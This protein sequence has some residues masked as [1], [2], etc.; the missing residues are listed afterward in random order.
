[1]QKIHRYAV[2]ASALFAVAGTT[3]AQD[4]VSATP[5][6]V[7]SLSAYNAGAAE[8]RF[9]VD[10]APIISSWSNGF[11]VAP[12]LKTS[13]DPD[14]L[15]DTQLVGAVALSPDLRDDIVFGS[16]RDFLV[17]T[18]AGAGINP[19][20]NTAGTIESLGGFDHQFA[21]SFVDLSASA[22]NAAGATIGLT[23]EPNR[24]YVTRTIGLMSRFLPA[25]NDFATLSIGA[26][27]ADGNLTVRAD[28]FNTTDANAITGDNIVQIDLPARAAGVNTL[29]NVGGT[30]IAT[31]APSTA[32]LVNDSAVTLNT[33]AALPESL[34]TPRGAILDFAGNSIVATPGSATTSTAH[35]DASLESQR[36]N[37]Y[38]S[39]AASDM[40]SDAYFA[41]L[42]K[43]SASGPTDSINIARLLA[44]GS[45]VSTLS[46]TL[47]SPI[48]DGAGYTANSAGDAQFTHYLS[49]ESFR[50]GNGQVAVGIDSISGSRIAAATASDPILGEFIAVVDITGAS[51][52]T[53]AAHIGKDVL[54]GENGSSIGTIASAAPA[55]ISAPGIDL[56]GHV[57]FIAAF[58]P[59]A[60]PAA[61][62]LIKAVNTASGYQLELLVKEGDSVTGV[63]SASAY[64]I[65][66]IALADSDSIASGSF[67]ASSVI[68]SGAG[69]APFG[70]AAFG[71]QITYDNGGTPETYDTVLFVANDTATNTLCL[72]DCDASGV[73]NF[74][75]LVSMLFLFGSD[76]GDGCDADENGNVD[77]NDLVATLF[78]F[79]PCP[80]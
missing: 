34:G 23:S 18:G 14:P 75:D 50:G 35:L 46:R 22:T 16:A 32:Y 79:G 31:D 15:F 17:W 1:M 2:G 74:N 40:T 48:T 25:A 53:V 52:W 45:V 30:N 62:A 38:I 51:G 63:N 29:I 80:E 42:G 64:T 5:G 61:N 7:D 71:A 57:Y 70:G 58:Q 77:F 73:V 69:G 8:I 9:V 68:Q 36:G 41:S 39:T 66:R 6:T 11:A 47:P 65:D 37:P 4:S 55:S 24:L 44:D 59:T 21:L 78:L 3:L 20:L 54:D 76:P 43:L 72:G 10:L 28:E 60:G 49:Q 19:A 33:P 27:D 56:D 67:F 26:I 13:A 12:V